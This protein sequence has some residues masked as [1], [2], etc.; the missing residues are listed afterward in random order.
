MSLKTKLQRIA[1]ASALFLTA[2]ALSIPISSYANKTYGTTGRT[3]VLS[4]ARFLGVPRGA[5]VS[6]VDFFMYTPVTIR[7][8]LK[9]NS[10]EWHSGATV[11]DATDVFQDQH[12]D[13]VVLIGHGSQGGYECADGGIDADSISC[14]VPK[15]SGDLVQYTCGSPK[16]YT[17]ADLLL[18]DNTRVYRFNRWSCAVDGYALAWYRVFSKKE[19]PTDTVPVNFAYRSR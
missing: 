17:L 4:N 19:K 14:Y 1:V 16:N 8:T 9:G 15:K 10:V 2:N 5:L 6:F 12:I 13:S 18:Q 3:A 11:E 7:E